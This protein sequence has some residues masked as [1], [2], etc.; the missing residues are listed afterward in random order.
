MDVVLSV[1]VAITAGK[2]GLL[3]A[4]CAAKYM[5][6]QSLNELRGSVA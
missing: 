5:T 6:E 4:R 2:N 3:I 1:G